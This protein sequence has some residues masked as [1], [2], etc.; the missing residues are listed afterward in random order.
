MALHR[1]GVHRVL[2]VN[3]QQ[4]RVALRS[5]ERLLHDGRELRVHD[6]HLRLAV[7]QHEGDGLRIQPGVQRIEHRAR[8]G[9]AKVRLH[10]GRRVGQHHGHRVVLANARC[11]AGRWPA[12]GSAHRPRAQVCAQRAV[13]DGQALRIHLGRAF[14]E[15]QRRNRREVGARC[16]A[17][18]G[19]KDAG[20]VS[21]VVPAG[22][23]C[24]Y[25]TGQPG[26][27]ALG[28]NTQ[29]HRSQ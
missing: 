24:R 13:H 11:A 28:K 2:H 22:A 5:A 4:R 17:G 3:H 9:D 1:A 20:I 10:H 29:T 15:V 12:G 23:V 19:R 27:I 18:P 16:A 8:H 14:N 26:P 7:V 25:C 21:P 6:H